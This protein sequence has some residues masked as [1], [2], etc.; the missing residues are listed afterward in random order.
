MVKLIDKE[1]YSATIKKSISKEIT[2][3]DAAQKLE[4]TER[5]V[6]RIISKYKQIGDNAFVHN[7]SGRPSNNKKIPKIIQIL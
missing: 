7:N 2:Q 5:Q 1:L 3:K 6:R 4:I